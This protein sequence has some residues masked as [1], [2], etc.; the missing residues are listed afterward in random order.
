MIVIIVAAS[1]NNIIGKDNDLL[2]HLPKDFKRFKAL[3]TGH[4]IIMGRKTF[5]S[6]PGILPNRKHIVVT[7]NKNYSKEGVIV[8]A[9]LEKAIAVAKKESEK[10]YIIGGGEIYKQSMEV[11]DIIELTRVHADIKGDTCFPEIDMDSWKLSKSEKVAKDQKHKYDFTF[12][13]YHRINHD[14]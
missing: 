12:L 13:T 7:R 2:W 6:L 1:E 4:P 10:I 8:V 3:T 9:S 14:S 5:Q 11:A